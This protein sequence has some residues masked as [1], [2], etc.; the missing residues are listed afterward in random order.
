M[1]TALPRSRSS[2]SAAVRNAFVTATMAMMIR[3]LLRRSQLWARSIVVFVAMFLGAGVGLVAAA[4][5]PTDN[6]FIPTEQN[7]TSCVGTLELPNCGSPDKS[8]L[9]LYLTFAILMLGMAFIGWRIAVIVRRR[10]RNQPAPDHT[11]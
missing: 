11:F 4:P 10:D 7:V 8:D 3:R 5:P 6:G 9:R 1:P 2:R